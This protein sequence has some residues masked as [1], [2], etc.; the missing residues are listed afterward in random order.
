MTD[1]ALDGV[2]EQVFRSA[3]AMTVD[4]EEAFWRRFTERRTQ[5]T[6][7]WKTFTA[8][9][10]GLNEGLRRSTAQAMWATRGIPGVA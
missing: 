6:E 1:D 8:V 4:E 2:L 10:L 7:V 9:M 5:E 3:F